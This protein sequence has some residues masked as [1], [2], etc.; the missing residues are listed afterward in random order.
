VWGAAAGDEGVLE[1][2]MADLA[3]FI[4][5][6]HAWAGPVLGLITFGESMVLIGAFFPATV[7][8]VAAG[9]L[10]GAGVVHPVPVLL[11]CIAGASAG[12]AVSYE[13]GRRLGPRAFRHP[14]LKP[15]RKALARARLFFRRYGTASIYLCRFMGPVRA[16]VPLIAGMMQMPFRRF[17]VAN[18]GSA[19]VW[20]PVMLAPGYLAA[21]GV[22]GLGGADP[23]QLGWVALAAVAA[24]AAAW[25]AWRRVKA[26][27]DKEVDA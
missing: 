15:H 11:W 1:E 13:L 3:G 16:F 19:A 23:H 22:Q 9:G 7:L 14:R 20:V 2:I 25:F 6:H 21:K 12:D 10:A 26:R 17:Q 5:R 8:M 24:T 4:E 18:V 27:L